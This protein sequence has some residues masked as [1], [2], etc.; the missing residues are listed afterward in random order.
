MSTYSLLL[1]AGR[2][3][4]KRSKYRAVK[5][6]CDGQSFDSKKESRV[7]LKLLE[8]KRQGEIKDL[9]RQVKFELIPKTDYTRPCYYI[10]DFVVIN[11][12]GSK[13]VIDAKSSATK[14]RDYVIKK[15]LMYWRYGIKI[16][17]I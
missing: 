5:T 4:K 2:V 16:V 7:Y 6:I 12:D 1:R 10:A 13:E 9:Q 15:K 3:P 11:T 14:T 8:R 17:E